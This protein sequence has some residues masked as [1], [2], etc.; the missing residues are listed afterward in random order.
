MGLNGKLLRVIRNMYQAVKSC[1]KLCDNY[2]DFFDLSIGLRHA[3]YFSISGVQ[4]KQYLFPDKYVHMA[5]H[6]DTNTWKMDLKTSYLK[7]I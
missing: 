4:F 2:S 1:V 7:L 5:T 3:Y 6:I